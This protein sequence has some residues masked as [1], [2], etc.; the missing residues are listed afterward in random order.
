MAHSLW[1]TPSSAEDCSPSHPMSSRPNPRSRI[2]GHLLR[3]LALGELHPPEQQRPVEGQLP[4]GLLQGAPA[5]LLGQR[6]GLGHH[7]QAVG[8]GPPQGLS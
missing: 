7:H 2:H 8:C 6:L 3:P 1:D 4:A 5:L